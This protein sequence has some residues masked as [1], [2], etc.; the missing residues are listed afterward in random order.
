MC[1]LIPFKFLCGFFSTLCVKFN[2]FQIF[3]WFFLTLSEKFNSLQIFVWLF[4]NM[5]AG[6]F[7]N[8]AKRYKMNWRYRWYNTRWQNNLCCT[9]PCTANTR[10]LSIIFKLCTYSQVRVTCY[11][12]LRQTVSTAA[13]V[14]KKIYNSSIS[15]Y[16]W[17]IQI[18][19][20]NLNR[21]KFW[22]T[23][24]DHLAPELFF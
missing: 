6:S 7:P 1:N 9:I 10:I 13:F 22:V 4:F 2:S 12:A 23:S 20:N 18:F 3:M 5:F 14:I 8:T 19:G 17:I 16:Q 24:R 15:I 21:T 11:G